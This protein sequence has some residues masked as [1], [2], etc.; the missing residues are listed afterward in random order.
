VTQYYSYKR[1]RLDRAPFN[2]R[3]LIT[4]FYVMMTLAVLVGVVNYKV[5]TGLTPQGTAAWYRGNED[6][7]EP[8]GE[9]LFPKSTR[10][11]L[12][13]THPHLFE[14]SLIVFVLCHLFGLT[15]V[16]ERR[17]RIVYVSSFAAVLLDIG[18]PWLTRFA[19]PGFAPVHVASS[20]FLAA[21]FLVLMVKPLHEMWWSFER[22]EQ[23]DWVQQ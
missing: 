20:L 15:R 10:E 3:L 9:L 17:K 23:Y 7:A 1:F 8:A 18:V 5:R 2:T 14:Q 22:E 11:L 6:A 12:D 21:M 13:V 19:G 16:H 4:C